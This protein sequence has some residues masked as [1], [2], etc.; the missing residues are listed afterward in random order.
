MMD[1]EV[2]EVLEVL[3][4]TNHTPTHAPTMP[5][6]QNSTKT[7]P[8]HHHLPKTTTPPPVEGYPQREA[9]WWLENKRGLASAQASGA[10]ALRR[11]GPEAVRRAG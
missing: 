6:S 10:P 9:V 3:E 8:T 11:M 1:V 5:H 2:R 7:T 4:T